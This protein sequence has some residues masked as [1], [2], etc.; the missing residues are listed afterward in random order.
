[1][2]TQKMKLT[3]AN[4]TGLGLF[5]LAM[6]TFVA[7]SQKLGITTGLSYVI[8][9]AIFLG[10]TAQ[11]VASILD[12]IHENVWGGTVFGAYAFFWY[13]IAVCWLMKMGVFGPE[14]AAAA[15]TRQLGFAF[16]GYLIFSVFMTIGA[17]EVSKMIFIIMVMI[18]ILL[19]GLALNALN[20]APHASHAV[21]AWAELITALLSFYACSAAVLNT[22]FGKPFLP[23]GKPFGIFK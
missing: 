5:G 19:A 6:V 12:F 15:D 23:M 14:L 20:I 7:A 4:P 18:D 8:V 3:V 21:A 9:Y 13:A 16:L 11:L 10:A 2:E 17:M 22:F 1:M